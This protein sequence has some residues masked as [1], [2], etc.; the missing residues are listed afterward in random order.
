MVYMVTY[1]LNNSGKNYDG[2][3]EAIK[4][5]SNGVWCTY[6]KS[7]FLIQSDLASAN[8]VFAKIKPAL[9]RDDRC[10]VIQVVNNYQGWLQD[11][12]WKYI[13]QNVFG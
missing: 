12:Q 9:D 6:W 10:I 4:S 13:N 5:A 8:D 3:I 2:V 11:D 7:A 1:D